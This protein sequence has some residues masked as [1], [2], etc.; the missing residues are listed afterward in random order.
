MQRAENNPATCTLWTLGVG[1]GD[2][3]QTRA[4]L[5]QE[6]LGLKLG[7]KVHGHYGLPAEK[8]QEPP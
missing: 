1:G 2:A 4:F 5:R 7:L 3:V 8:N 6:V